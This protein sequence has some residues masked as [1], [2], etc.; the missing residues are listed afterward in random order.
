MDEMWRLW[1]EPRNSCKALADS[2]QLYVLKKRRVEHAY[3]DAD[4]D[5]DL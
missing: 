1:R 2:V 5:V 3:K 4:G